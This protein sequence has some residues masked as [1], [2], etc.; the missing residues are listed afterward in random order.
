M[1]KKLKISS[2]RVD[3]IR[4]C[5]FT[6]ISISGYCEDLVVVAENWLYL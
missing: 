3:Y 5:L 6:S 1:R 4:F 2:S